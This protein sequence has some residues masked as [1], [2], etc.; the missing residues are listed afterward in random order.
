[1]IDARRREAPLS[2]STSIRQLIWLWLAHWCVSFK[3]NSAL[4]LN[5]NILYFSQHSAIFKPIMGAV[6]FPK[7]FKKFDLMS[8]LAIR[9]AIG[10]GWLDKLWSFNTQ[11]DDKMCTHRLKTLLYS[12]H[13]SAVAATVARRKVLKKFTENYIVISQASLGRMRH[14]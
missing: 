3:N 11:I 8:S 6:G 1:M 7:R 4:M 10:R 5:W 12:A 14:A 13:N 9:S 2:I